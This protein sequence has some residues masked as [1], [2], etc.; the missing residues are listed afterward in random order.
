MEEMLAVGERGYNEVVKTLKSMDRTQYIQNL[1]YLKSFQEKDID[2]K[3]VFTSSS[4]E[5]IEKYCELKSDRIGH[6]TGNIFIETK[7]CR[8]RN[9]DGN[10]LYTECDFFLYYLLGNKTLFLM[11]M[12]DLREWIESNFNNFDIGIAESKLGQNK[13]F[14]SEGLLV[15]ISE[16]KQGLADKLIIIRT[17][18]A[19][20][21]VN[22]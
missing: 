14:S 21:S 7:S 10:F 2:F 4:G 9:T 1:Q 11:K 5:Q 20:Q 17:T 18:P 15:P 19:T 3:W 6:E 12:E 22:G 13:K 8:E 16:L